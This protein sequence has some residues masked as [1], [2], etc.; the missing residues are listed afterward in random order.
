M[1]FTKRKFLSLP[2]SAQ[3]KKISDLLKKLYYEFDRILFEKVKEYEIW[4]R[5]FWTKDATEESLSHS[6]HKHLQNSGRGLSEH[7]FLIKKQ[8][9]LF[10]NE[11]WLDVDIYL[12]QIRSAQN[13][14]SIVRTT[15]AFRLGRLLF[16]DS[17]ANL[18]HPQVK[19]TSMGAW[20]N[21]EA[22]KGSASKF[23]KRPLIAIET[24]QKATPLQDFKFPKT[25]TLI[26]GNEE[27]GVSKEILSQADHIIEVPLC[28]LKN[29]LNVAACFSILA[30]KIN[31]DLRY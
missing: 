10:S 3:H 16:S 14:G 19:K 30:W 15:E 25:F 27:F 20:K 28:G 5:A 9:R 8:D 6:F 4:M 7:D 26:L 29:S 21:V 22:K 12:D 1:S 18:D 24:H 13:I 17:M 31:L 2:K 23:E 11:Q